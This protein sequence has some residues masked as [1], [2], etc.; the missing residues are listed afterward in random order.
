M[1]NYSKQD[2]E[3]IA[4]RIWW[5]KFP[6]LGH[7]KSAAATLVG[8]NMRQADFGIKT[9]QWQR[10]DNFEIFIE[11]QVRGEFPGYIHVRKATN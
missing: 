1:T 9:Y 10:L 2:L 5:G 11:S 3:K 4:R 7:Q 6:R 8:I